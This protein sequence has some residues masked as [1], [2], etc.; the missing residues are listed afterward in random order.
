MVYLSLKLQHYPRK[1]PKFKNAVSRAFRFGEGGAKGKKALSIATTAR[2]SIERNRSPLLLSPSAS[3]KKL[4]RDGTITRL[5]CSK[6]RL[7]KH[8]ADETVK[9]F[10]EQLGTLIG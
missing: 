2:A 3:P 7:V 9:L 5:T 6:S 8:N 10:R 4:I 1:T